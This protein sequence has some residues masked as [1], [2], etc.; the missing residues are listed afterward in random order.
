MKVAEG[1]LKA[2]NKY[3]NRLFTQ[4]F[5]CSAT[6]LPYADE[7]TI[8]QISEVLLWSGNYNNKFSPF[9]QT[10]FLGN[11]QTQDEL[12]QFGYKFVLL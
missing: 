7:G 1:G 11:G 2:Q 6:F 9:C 12:I 5:P 8:T 10:S 3:T 4:Q